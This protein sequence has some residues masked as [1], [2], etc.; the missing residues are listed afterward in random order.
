MRKGRFNTDDKPLTRYEKIQIKEDERLKKKKEREKENRKRAGAA[1][2][3]KKYRKRM[4]EDGTTKRKR[5]ERQAK[6]DQ[7]K[8]DYLD[9]TKGEIYTVTPTFIRW[10]SLEHANRDIDTWSPNRRRKNN[11]PF[12]SL[13]YCKTCMGRVS[14]GQRVYRLYSGSGAVLRHVKCF[15]DKPSQRLINSDNAARTNV[16]RPQGLFGSIDEEWELEMQL[17]FQPMVKAEKIQ[18]ETKTKIQVHNANR[19]KTGYKRVVG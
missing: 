13:P 4:E 10:Y 9:G 18:S 16:G 2:R 5:E 19:R 7:L 8:K 14:A 6:R 12:G 17:R 1:G 15:R 3:M 11:Y